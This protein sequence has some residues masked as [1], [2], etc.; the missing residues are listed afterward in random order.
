MLKE[1][2]DRGTFFVKENRFD[3]LIPNS[4]QGR[5][6]ADGV[7]K[8]DANLFAAPRF[9]NEPQHL[10]AFQCEKHILRGRC[11]FAFVIS[12]RDV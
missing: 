8:D 9:A 3:E 7:L 4:M 1:R 5:K 10:A 2:V 11:Y 12:K 6:R